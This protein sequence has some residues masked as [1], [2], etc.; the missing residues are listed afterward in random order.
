MPLCSYMCLIWMRENIWSFTCLINI[1]LFFCL[2]FSLSGGLFELNSFH[3]LVMLCL[4]SFQND[5]RQLYF[6]NAFSV[7][8]MHTSLSHFC[9][10]LHFRIPVTPYLVFSTSLYSLHYKTLSHYSSQMSFH[11]NLALVLPSVSQNVTIFSM[12]AGYFSTPGVFQIY[13]NRAKQSYNS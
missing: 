11:I 5:W 8:S 10:F 7:A 3:L 2:H 1:S 4:I 9:S 13:H 12:T 6:S